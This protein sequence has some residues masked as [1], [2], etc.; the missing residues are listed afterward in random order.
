MKAVIDTVGIELAIVIPM[1][2]A[3][4]ILGKMS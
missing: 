3:L 1:F 2:V 4:Y